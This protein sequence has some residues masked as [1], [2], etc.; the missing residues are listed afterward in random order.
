MRVLRGSE[1]FVT[2]ADGIRTASCFSFGTHFDPD[3]IGHGPL[4]ACND[5]LLAAGAGFALHRHA[6]IEIVTWVLSGTLTHEDDAGHRQDL[7]AGG[8]QRLSAGA[9]VRHTERNASQSSALRF[10]QMWLRPDHSGSEP[11]YACDVPSIQPGT[12][13]EAVGGGAAVGLGT[14][15][16]ALLIAHLPAHTRIELPAAPAGFVFVA[17]GSCEVD[18][19][20]PLEQGAAL[21]LSDEP[22]SIRAVHQSRLLAWQLP[23]G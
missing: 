20:L 10:V 22:V 2:A 19:A 12:W 3:Y 21:L 13:T 11:A 1:R 14:A 7:P 15:G 8:V 18:G 5:E 23:A 9:G 6:D 16:A 17:T 4:L